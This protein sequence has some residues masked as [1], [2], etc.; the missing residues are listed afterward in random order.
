MPRRAAPRYDRVGLTVRE[1]KGPREQIL[2]EGAESLSDRELLAAVLGTGC[3]GT[4]VEDLAELL[5][6]DGSLEALARSQPR[7]LR[8]MRGLGLAR[9]CQIAGRLRDRPPGLRTGL[10]GGTADPD[11]AGSPAPG[12]ALRR[13]PQG[14]LPGGAAQHAAPSPRGRDRLGRL[15]QLEHRASAR[16]L[17]SR[18]H[19]GGRVDHPRA[20]SS[21]GR[22]HP[23]G[24]RSGDHAAA[25]PG[26]RMAGIEVLDHVI[27]GS[28]TPFSFREAGLM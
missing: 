6:R 12:A 16:G 18:H 17:S 15:A 10:R 13:G 24:G 26:G 3:V 21:L 8:R 22:H 23:L 27:L 19:R 25:L 1:G 28:G 14:A 4:P 5:L 9:A 2:Q 11:A 20:Q 7:E